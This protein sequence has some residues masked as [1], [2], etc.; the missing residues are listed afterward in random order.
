MVPLRKWIWMMS[1]KV[2]KSPYMQ[3]RLSDEGHLARCFF[4]PAESPVGEGN[5]DKWRGDE[6]L[7]VWGE[8]VDTNAFTKAHQFS[9]TSWDNGGL[10]KMTTDHSIQEG[11]PMFSRFQ[12]DANRLVEI[13]CIGDDFGFARVYRRVNLYKTSVLAT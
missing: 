2:E 8:A 6:A 12:A 1:P 13:G 4:I 5:G 3:W 11:K 10:T 7:F 9:T